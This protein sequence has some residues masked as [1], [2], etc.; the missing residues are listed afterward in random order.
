MSG[1]GLVLIPGRFIDRFLDDRS[2]GT[3]IWLTDFKSA[4]PK[5]NR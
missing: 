2:P 1:E 5:G 4:N 3:M